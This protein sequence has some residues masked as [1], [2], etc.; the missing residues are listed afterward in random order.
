MLFVTKRL[1]FSSAHRL[2]NPQLSDDENQ[3]IFGKCSF[4]GGHGHNYVLEVTVC[5]EVDEKTGMVI[6]VNKLKGIVEKEIISRVDHKC[7]N[8]DVD[9]VKG[10]IPSVENM[11][12]K[13]W[14]ILKHKIDDGE[15]YEVKLFETKD[16]VATYRGGSD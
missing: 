16:N 6:N 2:F 15:L 11:V 5:G 13:I 8:T 1:M 3:R 7:L 12:V 10:M 9:F 4:P 14:G